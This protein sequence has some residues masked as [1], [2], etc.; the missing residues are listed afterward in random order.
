VLATDELGKILC[1][2]Y[3]DQPREVIE[4]VHKGLRRAS[5]W[6]DAGDLARAT[7]EAVLIG[8]PDLASPA[9][10]K[11]A[12]IAKLRKGGTAWQDQPRIPAGQTGGGEWTSGGG[13]AATPNNG[14]SGHDES[15][16]Q[17]DASSGNGQS[18]VN[19]GAI[20]EIANRDYHDEVVAKAA[21]ILRSLGCRVVTEIPLITLDGVAARADILMV[22]PAG[23]WNLIEVKTGVGP[24]YED[25]QR[26]VYPM[27]MIG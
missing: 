23:Q 2:A 21:R 25:T 17:E 12:N 24:K 20:D 26:L 4:H 19:P 3:G 22:T 6:L 14:S 8:V 16:S 27:A 7:L 13:G 5:D 9:V 1:L 18:E 15:A 10:A 11:L